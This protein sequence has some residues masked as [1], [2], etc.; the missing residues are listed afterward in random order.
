MT[1]SLSAITRHLMTAACVAL[2]VVASMEAAIAQIRFVAPPVSAPGNREAGSSRQ[3]SCAATTAG[4]RLTALVPATNI[5]LTTQ[6]LP[7]FF[8]YIPEN[9][10]DGAELRLYEAE[11]GEEV[12]AGQLSLPT[13]PKA[14]D[15]RQRSTFIKLSASEETAPMVLAAGENYIWALMLVCN[16][17]DRTKDIVATGIVQRAETAYLATLSEPVRNQ[18]AEIATVSSEEQLTTYGEA[19]LWYDFLE[20]LA[21]LVTANPSAYQEEWAMLLEAQGLAAIA[22]AP[23][24]FEEIEP[25]TLE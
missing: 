5:G 1:L 2:P 18:L 17:G 20:T 24:Q 7:S 12:Y 9:N 11:S 16:A 22:Q 6:S 8:A 14:G 4:Q 19:G 15:Y 21:S 3:E 10:A 13:A 25:L 23:L